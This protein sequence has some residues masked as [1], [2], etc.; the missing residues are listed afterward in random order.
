M[1]LLPVAQ[2][3]PAQPPAHG[4]LV[5][6]TEATDLPVETVKGGGDRWGVGF[7]VQPENCVVVDS[8][9][10]DCGVWPTEGGDNVIEQKTFKSTAGTN[11]LSYD[12]SPVLLESSYECDAKGF[13]AI[14][15][16][17]RARRQLE[18]GTS[19][20]MEFELWTGTLK[21]TN[22]A[23]ETGATVLESGSSFIPADAML[24]LGQAMS[25]CG[26][27]GRGMIHAPTI[28][29][30]KLL[31]SGMT[32]KEVGN[33]LMT[34]TRGDTIVAGSGYPGTGPAGVAPGT[35]QTWVFATGPVTY[36]MG[37]P[38]IYPEMFSEAWDRLKNRVEYRAEREVAMNFDPCCH[39]A[40]LVDVWA[41]TP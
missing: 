16:A 40:I 21:S 26:A 25:N 11:E 13:K 33:K 17:G 34:V 10:P 3:I 28:F 23:L 39:F 35:G 30:D 31:D 32:L 6:A 22:P 24:L 37:P 8:W 18:A 2:A 29:V 5:S 4:L 7:T 41:P 20:A 38:L 36:R 27:G 14:D 12:V 15:Y 19:K 1:N 9:D